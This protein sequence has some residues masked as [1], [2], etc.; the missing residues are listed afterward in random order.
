MDRLGCEPGLVMI[1]RNVGSGLS[2][3]GQP[4]HFGLKGEP[5]LQGWLAPSGRGF[6]LEVKTSTGRL[7]ADQKRVHEA[8]RAVGVLVYTVRSV[9]E[10]IKAL[11]DARR[12][13]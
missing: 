4:M 9:D 13:S 11:Q 5:D 1:R 10:A 7:S 6:C 3:G 12:Q 2:W 8:L